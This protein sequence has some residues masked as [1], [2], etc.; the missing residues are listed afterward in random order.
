M[1]HY[2]REIDGL[3]AIAVVAVMLYHASV[4]FVTGG[5]IGVDVFFV[6]SGF[7]ITGILVR[8]YDT[9]TLKL[10]DFWIR[11]AKRILP[12]LLVVLVFSVTLSLFL[13]TPP[14]LDRFGQS[15]VSAAIFSSNIFFW[16]NTSSYFDP[17]VHEMLLIHLWSLAVE[18][19]FYIFYPWVVIFSLRYFKSHLVKIFSTG[20]LLSLFLSIYLAGVAPRANFYLLPPRAWEL[21]AGALAVTLR[22]RNGAWIL[23]RHRAADLLTTVGLILILV[24]I[25]VYDDLTS[26]PGLTAIPPVLGTAIVLTFARP[27]AGVGRVLASKAFVAI[28][29]IS[30]SAYLWHQPL[31]AFGSIYS[32]AMLSWMQKLALVV[33]A[34]VFAWASYLFVEGPIRH[35]KSI[36]PSTVVVWTV[37]A[38]VLTAA[39]GIALW[40]SAGLPGRFPSAMIKAAATAEKAQARMDSLFLG[41]TEQVDRPPIIGEDG[42]V[43]IALL[44]DSHGAA[45]A[46]G[47]DAV[48][49]KSGRRAAVYVAGGAMPGMTVEEAALRQRDGASY[50]EAAAN[51]IIST[52]ALRTVILSARWTLYFHGSSQYRNDGGLSFR[53]TDPQAE[54]MRLG[55]LRRSLSRMVDRFAA[56]NKQIILVYPVPELPYSLPDFVAGSFLS[57]SKP[58]PVDAATLNHFYTT[59]RSTFVILDSIAVGKNVIKYYP[60]AALCN[61]TN[62][63]CAVIRLGQYMYTDDNHLSSLG[64]AIAFAPL[65]PII[66]GRQAGVRIR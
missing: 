48:L 38:Q 24:P 65:A 42:P 56:A 54:A 2:R 62:S 21:L 1:H 26:F 43:D 25:F 49:A 4:P 35:N 14:A 28:G 6:I 46:T 11:R 58:A 63:A 34:C 30:Y 53:L 33:V 39:A 15:L 61:G 32:F 12:A 19:Q 5:Y 51:K 16:R 47:L 66:N 10:A 50:L 59:S 9:G 64:S 23:T 44:G 17:N 3:R 13:L 45:M 40:M 20:L 29:L 31:L 57:H 37:C 8:Q 36:S 22:D 7:L 55:R 27:E 60:H 41:S 52:P 18:E